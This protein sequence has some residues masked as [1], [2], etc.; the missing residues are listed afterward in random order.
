MQFAI[1]SEYIDGIINY[2]IYTESINLNKTD[3]H[4][5]FSNKDYY[6]VDENEINKLIK[7]PHDFLENI[8]PDHHYYEELD[9]YHHCQNTIIN[10][11]RSLYTDYYKD[12]NENIIHFETSN[13]VDFIPII[14]QANF[15]RMVIQ[16][17]FNM[18]YDFIRFGENDLSHLYNK[19]YTED[20]KSL[21]QK[22]EWIALNKILKIYQVHKK[23]ITYYNEK[24]IELTSLS[25]LFYFRKIDPTHFFYH[26]FGPENETM[27]DKIEIEDSNLNF[28]LIKNLKVNY[29]NEEYIRLGK[30]MFNS[31]EFQITSNQFILDK[32]EINIIYTMLK[33]GDNIPTISPLEGIYVKELYWSQHYKF[34]LA[35]IHLGILDNKRVTNSFVWDVEDGTNRDYIEFDFLSDFFIKE[36]NLKFN[37]HDFN[38]F[39][40]DELVCLNIYANPSI[41]KYLLF[42]QKILARYLEKSGKVLTWV[43]K[44]TNSINKTSYNLLIFYDGNEFKFDEL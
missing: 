20:F 40:Q 19:S 8:G 44:I 1:I 2:A 11:I 35:N 25:L 12:S 30:I 31:H 27:N 16:E 39:Y 28:T 32:D 5:N 42:K 4:H 43:F 7:P 9:L 13:V 41:T 26:P 17:I 38:Y 21:G 3:L 23:N 22:Y 14:D 33:K 29:K 15:C 34:L 24:E 37:M 10:S 18:G 36:L 6:I